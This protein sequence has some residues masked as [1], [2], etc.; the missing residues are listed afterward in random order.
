MSLLLLTGP[1]AA[2]KN[3]VASALAQ[4]LVRCAVIDFD[5]LRLM[6][7]PILAPWDGSAGMHQELLAVKHACMLARSLQEDGR[8]VLILDVLLE[9]K[10]DLYR[11]L[12][13]PAPP[14]VV[15]LL[16][17]FEETSRRNQE[18]LRREG[19]RRLTEEEF[20]RVYEQQA[21]FTGHDVQIDPTGRQPEEVADD[22]LLL[23]AE[24]GS[25]SVPPTAGG[26]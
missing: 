6:M 17:S 19:Q 15:M 20:R 14:V 2:G 4:K 18:R 3:T 13:Q 16:P 23:L 8:D 22:L 10:L 7:Y 1:S 5:V 26:R 12:L 25:G 9:E 21:A 24:G 11:G